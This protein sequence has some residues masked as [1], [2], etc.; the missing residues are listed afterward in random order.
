M[1]TNLNRRSVLAGVAGVGFGGLLAACSADTPSS[2]APTSDGGSATVS[3]QTAP[4]DSLVKLLDSAGEV[5]MTPEMTEGPYYF[6]PEVVR[7]DIRED[8]EGTAL[9]LG[10]RV[11][12]LPEATPVENAVVEIWHCD[13]LGVYSG[14]EVASGGGPGGDRTDDEIYLRG[15]Q[16][17]NSD[18]I[19]QFHTVFPGWYRGRTVHIHFTVHLGDDH[20][21]TSQLFFDES[22]TATVH[23]TEP[24]KSHSG[25]DT[26]NSDDGIYS[27]GG[28]DTTLT[29]SA[30]EDGY[31]GLLNIGVDWDG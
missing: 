28:S 8:R 30:A 14:F 5:R 10:L 16:V 18:G 31:L 27:G 23:A 15:A 19:A 1:G 20:A 25:Q 29:V 11:V 2:Q 24:Y 7:T 6:D 22:I 21:L 26:H 17:T 4:D 9:Q 3:P 12:E 13:A